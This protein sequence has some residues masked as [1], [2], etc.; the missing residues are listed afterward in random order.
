MRSCVIVAKLW[1]CILWCS[2]SRLFISPVPLVHF[3]RAY[4]IQSSTRPSLCYLWWS[5]W[6]SSPTLWVMLISARL[7]VTVLLS[8]HGANKFAWWRFHL[9]WLS[10]I[11]QTRVL[12]IYLRSSTQSKDSQVCRCVCLWDKCVRKMYPVDQWCIMA[13]VTRQIQCLGLSRKLAIK[14][15]MYDFRCQ[16]KMHAC[17]YFTS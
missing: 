8:G 12:E 5:W 6:S 9:V 13:S 7:Y 14:F 15:G 10:R 4:I 11:L 1:P 3:S 17:I 2:C 16:S